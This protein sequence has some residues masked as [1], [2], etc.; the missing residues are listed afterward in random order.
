MM[1][2]IKFILSLIVFLLFP[3]VSLSQDLPDTIDQLRKSIVAIGTIKGIKRPQLSFT[4]TGFV[5]GNG[6]QVITNLH[7][8]PKEFDYTK[9]ERLTVFTGSGNS[10]KGRIAVIL[11]SDTDHDLVLLKILGESLP[12]VKLDVSSNLREGTEVAF[13]GFPIGMVLGLFP[14][15]HKG[16]ISAKS[17]IVIPAHSAKQ[18]TAKMI[19]RMKTPFN[20]YQIDAIAYPGNSGS[21]VYKTDTGMVV[22][23]LN[24]VYVKGTKE[25]VLTN[26][27]GISYAIPVQYAQDLL[28]S[29][30]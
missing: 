18:L 26:P 10:A 28:N 1:M 11:K 2:K 22:G 12:A 14:V 7:V 9:N 6:N 30:Q 20:V 19:K 24:S 15:T 23:I 21:P 8:I 4:G 17:P 25:S 27:S 29:L 5:V 16:I 3:K 13:T